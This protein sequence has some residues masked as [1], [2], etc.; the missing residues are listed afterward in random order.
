MSSQ[1]DDTLEKKKKGFG[2]GALQQ[3]LAFASHI[4]YLFFNSF[5]EFP[6]MV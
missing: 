3:L 4:N 5:R 1:V 6:T 2:S